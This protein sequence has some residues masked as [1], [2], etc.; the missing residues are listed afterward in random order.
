[1]KI[2]NNKFHLTAYKETAN[3]TIT[4]VF[5]PD[6]YRQNF[7]MLN[8]QLHNYFLLLGEEKTTQ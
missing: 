2:F 5:E 7:I 8:S 3:L 1:M 6:L 4:I